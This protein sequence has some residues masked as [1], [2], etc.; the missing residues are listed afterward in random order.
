MP[1]PVDQPPDD[2]GRF[3]ARPRTAPTRPHDSETQKTL[4]DMR[5]LYDEAQEIVDEGRA[6]FFAA[7]NQRTRRAATALI[8]HLSDASQRKEI[9]TIQAS[10][11]DVNW[12]G[13][14]RQR[15]HLGHKYHDIDF[16]IVWTTIA[17]YFPRERKIL[18]LD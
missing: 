17:E 6:S 8:I 5:G 10:Y 14:K 4:Q 16:E 12:S 15:D 2:K 18:G 1:P 13:L 11:P 9:V 3:V 7:D